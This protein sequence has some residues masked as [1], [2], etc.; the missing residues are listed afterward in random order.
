MA[1]HVAFL[2]AINTGNRRAKNP[3]LTEVLIQCGATSAVSFLASGNVIF[4]KDRDVD[5]SFVSTVEGAFKEA[6]GFD[7]PAILRT[8]AQVHQILANDALGAASGE[9]QKVF[10]ALTKDKMSAETSGAVL[11]LRTHDDALAVCGTEVYWLP[12]SGRY[13]S[14]LDVS[15]LEKLTG[16]MTIRTLRTLERIRDKFL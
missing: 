13:N 9:G 7:V 4:E 15:A 16:V 11:E 3:Q 14:E 8:E 10:V 2:R 5:H 1:K 6:L 12:R